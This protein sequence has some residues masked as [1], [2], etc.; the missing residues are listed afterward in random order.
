MTPPHRRARCPFGVANPVNA[1]DVD[2]DDDRA[3]TSDTAM[4][5]MDAS[6]TSL[7]VTQPAAAAGA[8]SHVAVLSSP[9][10]ECRGCETNGRVKHTYGKRRNAPS[11]L[12][13]SDR[14]KRSRPSPALLSA[15]GA[16]YVGS[17][18]ASGRASMLAFGISSRSMGG[19]ERDI[20][21][22]ACSLSEPMRM[23]DTIREFACKAIRRA[24]SAPGGCWVHESGR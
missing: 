10:S 15:E 23:S 3:R 4:N 22:A 16:D 14:A 24:P 2:A 6:E 19:Y 11:V 18:S 5:T 1:D 12:H 21:L 8:S 13:A 17:R 20:T 7:A 9:P